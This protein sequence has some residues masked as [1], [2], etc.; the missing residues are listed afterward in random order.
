MGKKSRMKR[1]RREAASRVNG[2]PLRVLR[3]IHSKIQGYCHESPRRCWEYLLE[4]LAHTAGWMTETSESKHLWDYMAS[5]HRW[6]EFAES[7]IDEVSQAKK[8]G[9]SF[10]EPIGE[11]LQEVEATN[12]GLG[13]F[14][15]PMPLVRVMNEM[16]M[17]DKYTPPREDGCP[18][19]RGLDPTCGTGRFVIDALVF[20][21]GVMM[22]AVDI[23]VWVL[24]A[25]MLNVR[26]LSKWTSAF[27]VNPDDRMTALDKETSSGQRAVVLGGRSIFMHGDASIVDLNFAPNWLCGGWAWSPRE[28]RTNLKIKGYPGT[29]D[30]YRNNRF[31]EATSGETLNFDYSMKSDPHNPP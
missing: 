22:H 12:G 16:S 3:A 24:R 15:T 19:R 4:M 17:R 2:E 18:S 31:D 9:S 20:D 21:D 7:W 8:N 11:L 23:D 30:D 10:S 29:L 13:Q 25:A 1:A 14:L 5:E 6:L 28:W 27:M 26:I